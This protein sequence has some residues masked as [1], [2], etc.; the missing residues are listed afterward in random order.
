MNKETKER[1]EELA[2]LIAAH[3]FGLSQNKVYGQAISCL[4]EAYDLGKSAHEQEGTP[5]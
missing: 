4:K 3:A 2:N 1:I 5:K